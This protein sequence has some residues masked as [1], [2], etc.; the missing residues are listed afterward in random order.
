MR[1]NELTKELDTLP[2]DSP[3][4]ADVERFIDHAMRVLDDRRQQA[5]RSRELITQALDRLRTEFK[6]DLIFF[7]IAT[8][9]FRCDDN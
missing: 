9:I 8:T 2:V 5:S 6:D 7:C 1:W 4:W 3:E